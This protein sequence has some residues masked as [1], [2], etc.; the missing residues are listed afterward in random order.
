V[1]IDGKAALVTGG[2]SGL[3]RATV[4]A[5]HAAGANV[6]VMDLPSSRGAAVA[7]ELGDRAAFAPA[8]VTSPS[9]VQAAI[10]TALERFG[11]LHVA[12]NCAG[13]GWAM[14]TVGRDGPHDLDIFTKVLQVN[15][16]GTF[17]VIRL[18]AARIG[19]EEPEDGERGVIVNTSSIAAFDGQTG[20]AAYA[21]SKGAIA[22]LTL[23]VARDLSRSLI[24]CVTI[25]PGTFD[26]P[27]MAMLPQAAKDQLE[28]DTPHPARLGSPA[29]YSALV[30]HVIENPMLNGEVIRLDGALRMPFV[31]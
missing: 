18:A 27:L 22:S 10:D 30:R 7:D 31:R 25:A 19:T 17:N 15:V 26:T 2:A 14:R 11:G 4:D 28:R 3:G 23:P 13:I 5:L 21:S 24:R 1:R 16:V 20:Q 12:V 29:E 9:D 8:D 6:L